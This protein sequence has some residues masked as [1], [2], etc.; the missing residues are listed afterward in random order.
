MERG[1]LALCRYTGEE[2]LIGDSIR[3]AVLEVK[4]KKVRLGIKAPRE[5]EVD[6]KE[7]RQRKVRNR[8]FREE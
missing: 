2:I 8:R 1:W 5:F 4:G 6:R 7:V 3:V